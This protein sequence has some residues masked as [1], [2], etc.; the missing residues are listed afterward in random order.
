MLSRLGKRSRASVCLVCV[1]VCVSLCMLMRARMLSA[2]ASECV[3]ALLGDESM[4]HRIR[5]ACDAGGPSS[6]H[7]TYSGVLLV[8]RAS[9]Y[10]HPAPTRPNITTR[11]KNTHIHRETPSTDVTHLIART[12]YARL[13]ITHNGPILR[14]H[15]RTH[16]Q[17]CSVYG[18]RYGAKEC[19]FFSV[20]RVLLLCVALEVVVVGGCVLYC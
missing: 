6:T 3:C 20:V 10:R 1:R 15:M 16:K 19:V 13:K 5:N 12:G 9:S 11:A 18:G 8:Y 17:I 2:T 7:H 14:I 4:F